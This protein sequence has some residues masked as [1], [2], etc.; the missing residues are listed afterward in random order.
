MPASRP[1]TAEV[2]TLVSER[3]SG[4]FPRNVSSEEWAS[5]APFVR[6]SVTAVGPPT[7]ESATGLMGVTM[8]FARWCLTQGLPLE[9]EI[10]FTPDRV[11]DYL[12]RSQ[13]PVTKDVA[14][15]LRRVGR[16]ATV[17]APWSRPSQTRPRPPRT[18][19]YSTD[20]LS[21]L[22]DWA[23]AQPTARLR[24]TAKAALSLPLAFGLTTA[25]LGAAY[26]DDVTDDGDVVLLR[27]RGRRPRTVPALATHADDVRKVVLHA[28]R[29]ERLVPGCERIDNT[30][31]NLK[32]RRRHPRLVVMR[33]RTTW[34]LEV[35]RAGASIPEFMELAGVDT[36]A[37]LADLAP[38]LP[39]RAD[40]E[41]FRALGSTPT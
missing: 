21:A 17:R 38:Y 40:D 25:E 31:L 6:A 1:P 36:T 28:P 15:R 4:Y 18:A 10:V 24:H 19:P 22:H 20:D 26:R 12:E 34:C 3:I 41:L 13:I 37:I 8:Q 29:G 27:V 35:L 14:T 33:L 7:P 2:N 39:R 32:N 16:A 9:P 30:L 5:V 11:D 23:D